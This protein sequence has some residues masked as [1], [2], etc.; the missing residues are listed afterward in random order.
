M[1][2]IDELLKNL[3]NYWERS[4]K[5]TNI[6]FRVEFNGEKYIVKKPGKLTSLINAGNVLQDRSFFGTRRFCLGRKGLKIEVK[7]LQL[8]QGLKVPKFT[9]Y[10]RGTLIR[11]FLDGEYFKDL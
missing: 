7:K 8:L 9:D 3:G 4:Y 6:V 2:G 11:E 5:A 10:K 1:E